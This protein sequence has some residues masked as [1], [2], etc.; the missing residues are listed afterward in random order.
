MA[1]TRRR[2]VTPEG[3]SREELLSLSP[4][5]RVM[6]T[7]LR[8]Y[9]DDHGR[10]KVNPRLILSA[11]F[12]L[13]EGMTETTIEEL[14][15]MLDDAGCLTL[16]DVRGVTYFAVTEWPS[17]DRPAP[18]SCPVPPPEHSRSARDSFANDS[19]R[20]REESEGERGGARPARSDRDLPPSP[21]C[22][23]HRESGGTDDPCR[24][25]GRARMQRKVYDDEHMARGRGDDDES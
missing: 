24:R 2:Y 21:F 12:P 7:G 1:M 17:V 14:L 11:I 9:A 3:F 5:A 15:L 4:T 22:E 16:Y 10:A 23:E 13:D 6:E 8:L 18:S 25:C 20:G 19:W